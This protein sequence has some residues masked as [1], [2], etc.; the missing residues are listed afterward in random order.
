MNKRIKSLFCA[1]ILIFVFTISPTVYAGTVGNP[2]DVKAL[3]GKGVFSLKETRNIPIEASFDADVVLNR[4]LAAGDTTKTAIRTSQWYLLKIGYKMFDR[5]EPYVRLGGAHLK[6]RWTDTETGTQVAM[7]TSSGFA[8]GLGIKALIYEF[9][10]PNI[11]LICDGSYRATNLD[12]YKGYLDGNRAA[13]SK[14]NSRFAIREW[15]AAFLAATEIGL[16]HIFDYSEDLK[17]YRL[18]PYAGIKYS[19]ISGRLR[20][21]TANGAVYHPDNIKSDK[22]I[23]IVVGCDLVGDDYIS[24]NLEGRFIDETAISTGLAVLF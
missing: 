11:K 4:D 13:I 14:T 21:V 8:W 5:I 18:S 10:A 6:A 12:P 1:G 20:M 15:Q 2:G 23:G 17:G 16:P 19:D 24:L 7:D 22:N 9:K 3:H